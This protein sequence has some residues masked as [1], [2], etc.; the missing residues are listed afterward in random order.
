M[1]SDKKQA[2]P[3]VCYASKTLGST[4]SIKKKSRYSKLQKQLKSLEDKF[5]ILDDD[6]I[7]LKWEIDDIKKS[8]SKSKSKTKHNTSSDSSG[9]D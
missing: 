8:L 5:D 9:S 3:I 2:I 6:L 7:E 1:T 4:H